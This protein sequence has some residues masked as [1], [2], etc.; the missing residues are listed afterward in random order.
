MIQNSNINIYLK[1]TGNIAM[2]GI[3]KGLIFTDPKNVYN[4]IV[5]IF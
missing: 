2:K 5:L 1:H 3:E 4:T